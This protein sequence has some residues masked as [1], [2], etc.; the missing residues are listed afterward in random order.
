MKL[1]TGIVCFLAAALVLSSGCSA[2]GAKTGGNNGSPGSS[3][4][5]VKG[6]GATL[7]I[8]SHRLTR[9]QRMAD[10]DAMWKDIDDNYPLMGVAERTTGNDFQKIRQ[11]YRAQ[12]ANASSDK[13]FFDRLNSCAE[14]FQGCGHMCLV[15]QNLYDYSTQLYGKYHSLPQNAYFYSVL[16]NPASRTFYGYSDKKSYSLSN[17]TGNSNGNVT[18]IP[19]GKGRT[20]CLQIHSFLN[21]HIEP[22]IPKIE[23]FFQEH[24][25]DQNCIID[26]RG[27]GGGDDGYWMNLIVEPNLEKDVSYTDYSLFRGKACRDYLATEHAQFFPISELPKLSNLNKSDL[28]Q[29]QYFIKDRFDMKSKI[30]KKE[31]QGKFYLLTDDGVY[32]S[33]EGFAHFCKQ[34]GFATI[35]GDPTGGDGI[36]IA[37]LFFVLPNSGICLRFSAGLGLNPDG[38]SNEEFGTTPDVRCKPGED[39]LQTCLDLIEK[40]GGSEASF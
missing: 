15:N 39:A 4:S 37:P 10:Y 20:V 30:G 13:D 22:D 16:N 11:K 17:E 21:E 3:S 6:V 18:T 14:N 33:A 9:E 24:A 25:S 34:T 7:S 28:A 5:Q 12:V 2:A 1:K 32:S 27:N 36:G 23:K 35:V 38:G 31:F 26:I 19:F 40:R 29:M 8:D